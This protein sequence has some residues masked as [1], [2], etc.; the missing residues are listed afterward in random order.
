MDASRLQLPDR[1]EPSEGL[2]GDFEGDSDE[3]FTYEGLPRDSEGDFDK[4]SDGDFTLRD[5]AEDFNGNS[6][7]DFTYE[8]LL[9]DSERDFDW[10]SDEYLDEGI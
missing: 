1:R 2:R 4:D 10:D 9:R 7:E 5:S 3:D 6:D 8:G